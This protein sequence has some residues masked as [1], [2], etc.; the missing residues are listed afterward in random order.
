M[1]VSD[2]IQEIKK[3]ASTDKER[4]LNHFKYLLTPMFD[5]RP[6]FQEVS[7]RKLKDRLSCVHCHKSN[8]IRFGKFEV[9]HGLKKIERQRYRCKGCQKTFTEST[10]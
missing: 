4:V 8:V 6:V 1:N 10:P 3:S 9:S 7:L 5:T 2:I